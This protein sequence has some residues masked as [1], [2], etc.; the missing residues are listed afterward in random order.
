MSRLRR[1]ISSAMTSI[2]IPEGVSSFPF[3]IFRIE[4]LVILYRILPEKVLPSSLMGV[5]SVKLPFWALLLVGSGRPSKASNS[6]WLK[7]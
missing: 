7:R 4:S 3:I 5:L 6:A 1:G 2:N